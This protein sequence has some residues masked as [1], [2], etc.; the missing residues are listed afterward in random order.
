MKHWKI[1]SR[2]MLMALLPGII[3]SLTLGLFFIYDRNQ[4]LNDLLDRRAMA[5]A[6]QL[7][8]TCEY[9]VMSGN[10]GILQN[11]A[12]NMLEERD[13]R[14]VS[15][16]NQDVEIL[17]HS[18]PKMMTE[19]IGSTELQHNQLQLLRTQGSVRV[20]APVF[21]E[22]LT[23]TEQLSEQFYADPIQPLQLL[24]WAEVELS[25]T[26]TQLQQYQHLANSLLVI[27]L[28]LIACSLLAFRIS[29][30]L[31]RPINTLAAGVSRLGQGHYDHRIQVEPGAEFEQMASD[32]NS[33]AS[34]VEYAERDHQQNLEQAMQ[35]FQETLDEME[36]RNS[37]LQLGRKQAM[38]A[39]QMKSQFLANVSHEIRTPL[40]GIIGFTDLLA[41]TQMNTLQADYLSTIHNASQDL[42]N[43]IN[44]ILDLSKIDADKLIMDHS[45]FNLRE[46][47]DQVLTVLAPQAYHKQLDLYH[48]IASDVPLHVIGDPLRLKQI[49]TNLVNNAVKFTK[50]GNVKV[51]V[52]LINRNHKR[53]SLQFEIRDTGIGLSQ[54]QINRIFDAFSQ[55]DTSTTRQ[56][57]GTGLG[58]II[59][60]AL[61]QAMH[62]DI[63]VESAPGQ[64]AAFI[65][66]IDI[67]IE[68]D[69][70]E[71]P[72]ALLHNMAEPPH[73]AVLES[74]DLN[75]QMLSSLLNEWHLNYHLAEDEQD[76]L[77]QVAQES[78]L[79]ALL[80]SVDRSQLHQHQLKHFLQQLAIL[81]TPV[82]TLINSVD[83]EHLEWLTDCGAS[84]TLSHPVSE[85]K[86]GDTLR[87]LLQPEAHQELQPSDYSP[88]TPQREAPCILAVDD[89]EAN[90]KLVTAL[91]HELGVSVYA[92]TSG[93]EAIDCVTDTH[94]EMVLM[95]IQM[96]NMTGLEASQHIRTLPGK[97]HLPIVA[98]TAHALADEK[99][100]LLNSGMDEYQTKPISLE[101]LSNCIERWTGYKAQQ[102]FDPAGSASKEQEAA[103][104]ELAVFDAKEGLK[105]A[106][107]NL[108]LAIDMF[109]MLLNSLQ[110]DSDAALEAW[111]LEDF[112][113]LIEKVHKI[114]GACRYCGVPLLRQT[115]NDFETELKSGGKRQLPEH[116]RNFMAQIQTLQQWAED[117]NW[118]QTLAITNANAA[119]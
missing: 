31:S 9:G 11:I 101:Q 12:N 97:A 86:L 70:S 74:N 59:S 66:H 32:V 79:S 88:V 92:A 90:L 98:L 8:P 64:G 30:Q 100:V 45:S 33:L 67:G 52:S 94:I 69:A 102:P 17:A 44:D 1:Q 46:V 22:N 115:V 89:N 4:D 63:K 3:V 47:V 42:L 14:S 2:I 105:H 27:L 68:Q 60:K 84:A 114:H 80:I 65:F 48:H 82:I 49:I 108:E 61:V 54:E 50:H 16:Y 93:Q 106:N 112:E 81:P 87:T 20:R 24:G 36:V 37:E 78:G 26:N 41:R 118:Q 21:A 99:E 18:G 85:Q 34:A 6:K 40:N 104:K 55:A 76:L 25:T 96:P 58:L 19:R 75:R 107:Y 5:M 119:K 109:S 117:N 28:V 62:G 91:L 56:Y 35:D 39:S 116:M 71:T 29:K 43:I 13:V 23:I 10:L 7:A 83:H 73:I 77:H 113:L 38:E 57:G 51:L 95:D 72:V 15:I 103:E 110:R 53:A 111:E